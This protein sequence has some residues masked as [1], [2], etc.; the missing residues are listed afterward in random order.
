MLDRKSHVKSWRCPVDESA[1]DDD[2]IGDRQHLIGDRQ[3]CIGDRQEPI[4]DR[5]GLDKKFV[6][7]LDKTGVRKTL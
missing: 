4:D 2:L 1:I 6:M 3:L 7:W 5:Q